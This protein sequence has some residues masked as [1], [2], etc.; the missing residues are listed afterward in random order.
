MTRQELRIGQERPGAKQEERACI[1]PGPGSDWSL[2]SMK[3]RQQLGMQEGSKSSCC[4]SCSRK[5]TA[6]MA[7][8]DSYVKAEITFYCNFSNFF[9]P[10]PSPPLTGA[11]GIRVAREF[12]VDA[13]VNK[14][15]S[16]WRGDRWLKPGERFF[17]VPSVSTFCLLQLCYQPTALSLGDRANLPG[18]IWKALGGV[19][20]C[21]QCFWY[22]RGLWHLGLNVLRLMGSPDREEC[23][24]PNATIAPCWAICKSVLPPST[25]SP[26]IYTHPTTSA[27][28]TCFAF[29]SFKS[30]CSNLL[31]QV[32]T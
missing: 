27:P 22:Q 3:N 19:Y 23:Y 26:G 18:S 7:T 17:S 6:W 29:H 16:Y 4:Y 13:T 28:C 21:S 31:V 25:P 15:W 10:P 8:S 14:Y 11:W 24:T 9:P 5:D 32:K 12:S 1:S 30:S 20:W 2:W